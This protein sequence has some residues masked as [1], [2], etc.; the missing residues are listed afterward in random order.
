MVEKLVAK[1][2]LK[3][4][5]LTYLSISSP[6]FHTVFLLHVRVEAYQNLL[7]LRCRPIA[8]ASYKAFQKTKRPL[9][10][11]PLPYFRHDF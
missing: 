10:L 9:E 2:F 5:N 11:V 7:K 6:K 1:P 4:Q 3:N 8:F